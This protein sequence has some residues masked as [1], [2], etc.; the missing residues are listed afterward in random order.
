MKAYMGY[1]GEDS[2]K[3][4]AVQFRS[5]QQVVTTQEWLSSSKNRSRDVAFVKLD[6][7]FDGERP[8]N[9]EKTPDHGNEILGVVGYPLDK[10]LKTEPGAQ[11][12]EVCWSPSLQHKS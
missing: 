5:G 9:I 3:S 12:Y 10:T 6:A 1:N 4:K 8:F 11:M 2:L 7:P